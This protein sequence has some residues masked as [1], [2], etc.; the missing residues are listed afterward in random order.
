[1]EERA[2]REVRNSLRCGS[3]CPGIDGRGF[4]AVVAVAAGVGAAATVAVLFLSDVLW[5]VSTR[6][7]VG[8]GEYEVGSDD[9]TLAHFAGLLSS[10]GC[11]S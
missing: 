7:Q 5:W 4:G 3:C 11:V 8:C 9:A 6:S 1:V 2:E 10:S